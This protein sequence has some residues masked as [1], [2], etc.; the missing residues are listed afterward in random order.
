MNMMA[1]PTE[2]DDTPA[3]IRRLPPVLGEHTA[4]VLRE[5]GLTDAEIDAAG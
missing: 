3:S 2:Y 1:I 4:S 5:A